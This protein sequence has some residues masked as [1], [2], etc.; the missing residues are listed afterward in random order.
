MELENKYNNSIVYKIV[1]KVT[2]LVYIGSTTQCLLQR[3]S[4]HKSTYR[5]YLNGTY[6]YVTSFKILENNDFYIKKIK[7]YNFDNNNDLLKKETYWIKKYKS[8]NKVIPN[9]TQ[10]EYYQDNIEVISAYQSEYYE[11]NKEIIKSNSLKNY[12]R[13]RITILAKQ[14]EV[15]NCVCGCTYTHNHK[16]RHEK[17]KK[18]LKL[19]ALI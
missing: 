10:I 8:V 9:R 15:C 17:T 2:G 5:R 7:S 11:N 4:E 6:N 14:Q 16:A 19:M 3:L 18:H 13:N 1:C 12:L